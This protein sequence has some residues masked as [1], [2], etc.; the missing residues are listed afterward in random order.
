M[1]TFVVRFVGD[2]TQGYR[3][4][5]RHVPSGEEANFANLEALLTFFEQAGA[6]SLASEVSAPIGSPEVRETAESALERRGRRPPVQPSETKPSTPLQTH[7]K[8][9]RRESS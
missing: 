3:G 2:S 7:R 1:S 5:V 4:R 8:A 9:R 6:A